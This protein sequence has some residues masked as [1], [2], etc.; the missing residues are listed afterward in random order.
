MRD[1]RMALR[2]SRPGVGSPLAFVAGMGV[3]TIAVSGPI[4]LLA[5]QHLS[6][7]MVQ[8]LGLI[9]IAAPLLALGRPIQLAL[10]L[11]GR[12]PFPERSLGTV[13]AALSA[14]GA[15]A[16]LFTW[17]IP[18]L[19]ALALRHEPVHATEHLTLVGSSMLLWHALL[20]ARHPGAGVLWLYIVT[21]PMTA[22]GVAMTIARTPWYRPY[23]HG[24]AL[25][26]VRDQQLAGVIMWGFGGMVAVVSAVAL[27]AHWLIRLEALRPDV[28]GSDM[29]GSDVRRL[30]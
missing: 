7:H 6:W 30:S 11:A 18:L 23:V 2:I 24:D 13:A 14:V 3:M 16:V 26:A 19:Y 27:F 8:H 5:E 9:S 29:R 1:P 15:L 28:P 22:F 17:H 20:T 10:R 12:R 21:L 25:A 4:D